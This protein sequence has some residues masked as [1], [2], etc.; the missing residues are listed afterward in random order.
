M[1]RPRAPESGVF[2][3]QEGPGGGLEGVGWGEATCVA[4]FAVEPG[5]SLPGLA[6]TDFRSRTGLWG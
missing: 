1:Q 2:K 4:A 5:T 6:V 3:E